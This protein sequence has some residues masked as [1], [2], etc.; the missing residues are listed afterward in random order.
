MSRLKDICV[1]CQDPWALAN[2]WADAIG[3]RVRPYSEEDLAQLRE[4]GI[5]GPEGDPGVALD[6]IDEPGPSIWFLKV[7]EPQTQRGLPGR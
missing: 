6:P 7:P 1:D 2:W 5:D 3:Y 4:Q